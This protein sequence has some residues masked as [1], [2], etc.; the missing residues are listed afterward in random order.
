MEIEYHLRYFLCQRSSALNKANKRKIS[1]SFEITFSS[2]RKINENFFS[3]YV[4]L[5]IRRLLMSLLTTGC[6]LTETSFDVLVSRN[7]LID[8]WTTTT[9]KVQL[10]LH[11]PAD[12]VEKQHF[13]SSPDWPPPVNRWTTSATTT[14]AHPPFQHSPFIQLAFSCQ[15]F[16]V[17]P[18]R[19]KTKFSHFPF[20]FQ[21]FKT[22]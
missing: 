13:Q 4:S 17:L 12:S 22:L 3:K 9:M 19:K 2:N 5:M 16:L 18:R 14:L 6:W 11:N 21:H 8:Q 15:T 1:I 7:N 20:A 10:E